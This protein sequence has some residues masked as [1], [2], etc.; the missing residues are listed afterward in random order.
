MQFP[1]PFKPPVALSNPHIQTIFSSVA[2]RPVLARRLREFNARTEQRLIEVSGVRLTVLVNDAPGPLIML[3]PGWLGSAESTYAQSMAALLHQQGFAVARINL[4]DHGGS[5]HLNEGLFHSALTD[6]VVALVSA[7]RAQFPGPQGL[8]GFSLGGNFAL[9]VARALPGLKTLAICPAIEP[10][11]T[12]YQIDRSPI[13][14]RYFVGKWQKL[15]REKQTAFPDQFDFSRAINLTTVNALTDYFVRYHTDFRNCAEYFSAY[16]LSGS[17]LA[18]VEAQIL[19]AEDDPIIPK[20]H[21]A[22]L[23]NSLTIETTMQGGHGAYLENWHLD[24]WVDR[25]ASHFFEPLKQG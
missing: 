2:R 5:V 18:G 3:I 23:P 8:V 19:L 25:Y 7:L 11:A 20:A 24:A 4:R 6:E 13:Y 14:Q 1:S 10:E 9:R 16:D 21:F 12:M 17:A 22:D 15:W